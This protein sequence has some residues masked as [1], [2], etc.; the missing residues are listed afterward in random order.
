MAEDR[1]TH[2]VFVRELLGDGGDFVVGVVVEGEDPMAVL[3][4]GHDFAFEPRMCARCEDV[5]RAV[6]AVTVESARE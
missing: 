4:R 5:T 1:V 3:T 6:V 2:G